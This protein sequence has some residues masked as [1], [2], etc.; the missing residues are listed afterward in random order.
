MFERSETAMQYAGSI[1]AAANHII[2]LDKLN[3]TI[4]FHKETRKM[5]SIK[6]WAW[7]FMCLAV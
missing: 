3:K 6:E 2:L 1:K 5:R 7:A 4:T